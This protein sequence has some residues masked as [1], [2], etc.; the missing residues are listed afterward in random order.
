MCVG[1]PGQCS[2]VAHLPS[3][4]PSSHC[5]LS[6]SPDSSKAPLS[7]R[8]LPAIDMA[9]PISSGSRAPAGGKTEGLTVLGQR[10]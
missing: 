5:L 7:A 9:G 8:Q 6:S 10:L 1:L 2:C 4:L 3:W